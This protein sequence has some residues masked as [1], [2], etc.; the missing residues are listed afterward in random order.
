MLLHCLNRGV[1]HFEHCVRYFLIFSILLVIFLFFSKV[2]EIFSSTLPLGRNFKNR[3]IKLFHCDALLRTHPF[4]RLKRN[5]CQTSCFDIL[6]N[7]NNYNNNAMPFSYG[8]FPLIRFQGIATCHDIVNLRFFLS[9]AL[10][11]CPTLLC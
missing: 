2:Y 7:N 4:L 9:L 8:L 5:M 1:K 10:V 11:D 3:E 6:I